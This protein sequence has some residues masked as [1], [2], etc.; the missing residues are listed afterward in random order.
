MISDIW[1]GSIKFGLHLDHKRTHWWTSMGLFFIIYLININFLFYLIFPSLISNQ[2]WSE[3]FFSFPFD[4]FF[5]LAAA[6][7]C[8]RSVSIWGWIWCVVVAGFVCFF[9][10]IISISDISDVDC[11]VIPQYWTSSCSTSTTGGWRMKDV[12]LKL[13][14]FD[15]ISSALFFSLFFSVFSVNHQCEWIYTTTEFPL[16]PWTCGNISIVLMCPMSSDLSQVTGT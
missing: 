5:L 12:K 2:A 14:N 1:S 6:A 13:S 3:N 16:S 11:R 10:F 7:C 9:I 8:A 15:L 4:L